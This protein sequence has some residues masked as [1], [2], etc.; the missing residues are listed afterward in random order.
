MS[1]PWTA[2]GWAADRPPPGPGRAGVGTL[3]DGAA[4]A[5]DVRGPD[6]SRHSLWPRRAFPGAAPSLRAAAW[7][8]RPVQPAAGAAGPG[9]Q[10]GL[11][12]PQHLD[13]GTRRAA[14]AGHGVL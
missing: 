13:A 6:L 7:A 4:R 9:G 8:L 12:V 2:G 10:R 14:A 11:P 5:G 3:A 1:L